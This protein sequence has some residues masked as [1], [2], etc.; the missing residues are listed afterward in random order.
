M[1]LVDSPLPELR[2]NPWSLFPAVLVMAAGTTFLVR[3]VFEAQRRRP[4]TG[5]EGLV[6]LRAIADSDL[7]PEGWVLV[8]G[9]RWR[10][11]AEERVVR[12]EPL[13]IVSIEGLR[14]RVR[15]GA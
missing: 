8:Q 6:G 14:L 3:M 5:A 13:A 15:K 9:E 1:M 11:A 10:A 7:E 2:V 12:G 4:V